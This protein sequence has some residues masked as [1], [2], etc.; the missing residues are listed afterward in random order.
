MSSR[1]LENSHTHIIGKIYF[2]TFSPLFLIG[3]FSYL[4]VMRTCIQAWMSLI[5]G[6]IQPLTTELAALDNIIIDVSTFFF[7]AIDLI[8]LNL[9]VT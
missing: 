2:I 9:Q 4:Q 5:F 8:L 6:Q 1:I 7:V 3:S